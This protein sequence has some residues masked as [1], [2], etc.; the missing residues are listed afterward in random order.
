MANYYDKRKKYFY[1][2]DNPMVMS[3][4][5]YVRWQGWMALAIATFLNAGNE[6]D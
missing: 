6:I 2:Y 4:I 1:F 5:R 3:K